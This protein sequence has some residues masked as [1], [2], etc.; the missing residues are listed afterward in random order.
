MAFSQFGKVRRSNYS[1]TIRPMEKTIAVGDGARR[2]AGVAAVVVMMIATLWRAFG[3]P[4]SLSM[5][6]V[7]ALILLIIAEYRNI[8][9][10][11]RTTSLI[12]FSVGLLL[13]PF[14]KNPYDAVE[15]GV[16]VAG[17]LLSQM[18]S[19]ILLARCALRS[20]AVHAVGRGLRARPPQRR[21]VSFTIA[22]QL[23]GSM[24]G[25]AGA[26]IMFVM[27]SAP[28]EPSNPDKTAAIVAITRG[29]TAAGF[30][31]P[32]FGN[33]AILLALYPSLHWAN[34]FPM[35]V[36]LAQVAIIVGVLMDR[37]G[38]HSMHTAATAAPAAADPVPA[39]HVV[40]DALP[41]LSLMLG[42]LGTILATS[43]VLTISVTA[44]IIL[45]GPLVALLFNII[46]APRGRR[47]TEGPRKLGEDALN[48][49]KLSSEAIIFAAAG[50]AGTIMADAFPAAWILEVSGALGGNTF[51]GIAFLMLS[52]MFMG[53]A[54][55][56]PILLAVF[57]A[58]T[59]TPEVLSLPPLTHFLAIL[60]GW[61]IS[62][63][64]NP[65]SLVSMTAGR[66]AG[67]GLYHISL[68]KNWFYALINVLVMA[69]I[70]TLLSI[71]LQ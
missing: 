50:C 16:F 35:G 18:A 54:G 14:A 47:L 23:F 42:L 57:M 68:G 55:I 64:I 63:C 51:L 40:R 5:V 32:M 29:F 4:S 15:R 70:L 28:D 27:A 66:Y 13:L 48:F 12:L 26:N 33:M 3:G 36:A 38:R 19:V 8:P 62:A 45:I 24:L 37:Y 9:S 53:L 39:H 52:I 49:S 41:L 65:Y 31:S 30:W 34:V 56:H 60:T 69:L 44:T 46:M 1:A 11:L 58:S 59:I 67:T 21:Y 22:S 7:L 43:K 61:G 6:L 71:A 20:P 25:L 10:S 17:L 2:A